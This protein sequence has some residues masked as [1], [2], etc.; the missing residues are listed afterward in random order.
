MNRLEGQEVGRLEAGYDTQ[1]LPRGAMYAEF[2]LALCLLLS[3]T[4]LGNHSSG[5]SLVSLLHC[6]GGEGLFTANLRQWKDWNQGRG[7]L[8][9]SLWSIGPLPLW[10]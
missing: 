7:E 2:V 10:K 3:A 9:F 6:T 8:K 1:H 4:D 5:G